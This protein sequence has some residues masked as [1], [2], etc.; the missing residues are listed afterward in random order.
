MKSIVAGTL[1]SIAV[2]GLLT[3][4]GDDPKSTSGSDAT[5]AVDASNTVDAGTTVD[6]SDATDSTGF[7]SPYDPTGATIP[8]GALPSDATIPQQVIDQ[9]ITQ[10]EQAGMKVDKACF[11]NLL[12]DE[13]LRKMVEAGGTPSQDVVQKFFTCLST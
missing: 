4:C 12:K 10:F 13:S 6:T 11:T 8:A 1:A 7:V 5:V 3:A 9:M 2:L